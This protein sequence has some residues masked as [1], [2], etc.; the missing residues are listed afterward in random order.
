MNIHEV[1]AEL[2]KAVEGLSDTDINQ[3]ALE[4][5]WTIGQVLEHLY[6]V[7]WAV[8]QNAKR[9]LANEDVI[10]EPK[11]ISLTLDRS[12]KLQAPA[13]YEPTTEPKHVEELLQKL[14]AART[15][16]LAVFEGAEIS[17]RAKKAFPHPVFGLLDMNQWLEFVG[18]HE[19]RH[20]EQIKEIKA[21]L[22]V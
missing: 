19:Q 13:P 18:L 6:L 4:E 15:S 16:L 5:V 22:V 17:Q 20:L 11:P 14:E 12:K 1:R 7:E 3:V 10:T 2:V 9:V 21:G 8:A